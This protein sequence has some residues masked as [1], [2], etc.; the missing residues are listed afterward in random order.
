MKSYLTGLECTAC[1]QTFDCAALHGTCSKCDGVLFARYDL[2]R[3]R[4]DVE[5]GRLAGRPG[6]MWRFFELL[7]VLDP[8]HVVTLGEGG[9]PLL[10]A[11]NLGRALGLKD[12]RIKDEGLNPTLTFKARGMAA[13]VS[14]ARELGVRRVVVPSAGNAAGAAAAYCAKAGIEAHVFMPAGAPEANRKESVALGG[15]VTLVEGHIGDVAGVA[16]QRMTGRDA[17]DLSTFREPYRAEG[18]KTMALELALDLGWRMPD[19]I[20]YPTGGGTGLVGM[21][22]GFQE[23]LALGWVEGPPPR[24][25]A[26]QA[27]GCQPI[28]QA[29]HEGADACDPWPE[30]RTVAQGL[31]VPKPFA[32]GLVL[33]ALRESGGTALAVSDD[34]MRDAMVEMASMEGVLPC[35]EGAATLCGLRELLATGFVRPDDRVVLLNTGSGLK[36]L[37]LLA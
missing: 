34:A 4:Q 35:P 15:H 7:P 20:V 32:D 3:L 25:V 10:R 24:M 14:K 16:R 2:D 9:T 23:L 36:Y 12:L 30:P 17:F 11:E 29:F 28:V 27:A 31:E 1:G 19:V 13:A 22:K 37:E 33:Q 8:A 18:K 26:V 5:P 6:A 21:W